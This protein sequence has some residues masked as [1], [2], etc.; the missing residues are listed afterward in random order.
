MQVDVQ[1]IR[2]VSFGAGGLAPLG[3]RIPPPVYCPG[4]PTGLYRKRYRNR[5]KPNAWELPR[6]MCD[7]VALAELSAMLASG[8]PPPIA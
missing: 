3:V 5:K 8:T 2:E 6:G 1:C 4:L 7:M